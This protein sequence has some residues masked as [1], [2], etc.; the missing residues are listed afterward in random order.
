MQAEQTDWRLAQASSCQISCSGSPTGTFGWAES[1]R[2]DLRF[3][4]PSQQLCHSLDHELARWFKVLSTHPIPHLHQKTPQ[5][6]TADNSLISIMFLFILHTFIYFFIDFLTVA[7]QLHDHTER[8]REDYGAFDLLRPTKFDGML[9]TLKGIV[10]GHHEKNSMAARK[11]QE[12]K[13][14]LTF[15]TT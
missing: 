13:S 12:N 2:A 7:L 4:R 11:S 6:Q 5:G 3:P 8:K 14:A 9:W 15:R 1:H 10:L